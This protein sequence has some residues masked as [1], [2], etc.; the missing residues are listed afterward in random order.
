MFCLESAGP[1]SFDVRTS[2]GG[3]AGTIAPTK[4]GHFR[5]YFNMNGT[6]GSAR[7]FANEQA[8]IEYIMARRIKKGWRC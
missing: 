6:K 4:A 5:V 2:R 7:K 3:Y 8:C 1:G